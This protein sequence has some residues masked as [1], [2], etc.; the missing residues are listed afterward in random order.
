MVERAASTPAAVLIQGETGTG[1]EMIARAVHHFSS[2]GHKPLID[3]NC[4]TLPEHLIESELFGHEKGAFSSAYETKPGLFELADGSSLFLDEIGELDLRMQ[5]KLLRVLDGVPYYRLGGTKKVTPDVRI[6]A[7][8]NRDLR[9]ALTTGKFR[10]DLY[11]RLSQLELRVP[12]LRERPEDLEAIA[13]QTLETCK[14]GAR[15]AREAMQ[16][17]RTYVWPGNIRELKSAVMKAALATDPTV[18]L[19]RVSD[20]PHELQKK[21]HAPG[22]E[23]VH[24]GD[25]DNMERAMIERALKEFNGDQTAAAEKLGISRRTLSRKIKTF[26]LGADDVRGRSLDSHSDQQCRYYRAAIERSVLIRSA[27]G[28]EATAESINVSSSGIGVRGLTD[29]ARFTGIVE[30]EFDL[31][32]AESKLTLKGKMTWADAQGA[33]GIRF[34]SMSRATEELI[35]RWV[36]A[37]RIEEGWV[38]LT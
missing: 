37:K 18:E 27:G 38:R 15:F 1:K 30:L 16:A 25:I 10:S 35:S 6:I 8:T 20:L 17:L 2:R 12:P 7:A 36:N 4:A 14:P 5:V 9:V 22:T 13:E 26:L 21:I 29:P 23:E 34:V 31:G 24:T 11:F 3:I 19:V 28:H 32:S 33:A